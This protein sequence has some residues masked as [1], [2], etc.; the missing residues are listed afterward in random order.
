[1]TGLTADAAVG[2]F[3]FQLSAEKVSWVD[4][5]KR[6]LPLARERGVEFE[7]WFWR[8]DSSRR[9]VSVSLSRCPDGCWVSLR[10][11]TS[12]HLRDGR[13]AMLYGGRSSSA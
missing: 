13:A 7:E 10:D 2:R 3:L 4:R 8:E 9:Y 6:A 12:R 5:V 1:M 11:V